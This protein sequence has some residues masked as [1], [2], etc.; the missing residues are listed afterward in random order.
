MRGQRRATSARLRASAPSQCSR[1][2]AEAAQLRLVAQ[3]CS[4]V[5]AA[6]GCSSSRRGSSAGS[7]ARAT[8]SQVRVPPTRSVVS[9]GEHERVRARASALSASQHRTSSSRVQRRSSDSSASSFTLRA[10]PAKHNAGKPSHRKR[11]A[12]SASPAEA[13]ALCPTTQL[14]QKTRK[15]AARWLGGRRDKRKT[16]FASAR[17]WK[18]RGRSA[19]MHSDASGGGTCRRGGIGKRKTC[20]LPPFFQFCDE[21]SRGGLY[22]HSCLVDCATG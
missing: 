7:N 9:H 4:H 5:S 10:G 11:T 3:L 15:R 12:V 21:S 16:A 22:P 17:K 14:S 13:S 20:P 8:A 1:H 6:S 2:S 19:T 18:R